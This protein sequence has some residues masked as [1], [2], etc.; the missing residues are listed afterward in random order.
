MAVAPLLLDPSQNV[1]WNADRPMCLL[2]LL[3]FV[4]PER[5]RS[6]AFVCQLVPTNVSGLPIVINTQPVAQTVCKGVGIGAEAI[7]LSLWA[8]QIVSAPLLAV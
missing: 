1:K 5:L 6:L 7:A 3:A 4:L 2:P 8:G